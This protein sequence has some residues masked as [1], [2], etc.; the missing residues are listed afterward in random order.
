[1]RTEAPSNCRI[2][3]PGLTEE[4][5]SQFKHENPRKDYDCVMTIP[6]NTGLD[7]PRQVPRGYEYWTSMP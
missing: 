6:D 7:G 4:N 5:A 3:L 1:M 2:S